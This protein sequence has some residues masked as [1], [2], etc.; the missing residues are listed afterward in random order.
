[1]YFQTYT[2]LFLSISLVIII[3]HIYKTST[4][5]IVT[6]Q[7]REM[8]LKGIEMS[9]S[10]TVSYLLVYIQLT[11][12]HL[13]IMCILEL[14]IA[15]MIIIILCG[16]WGWGIGVLFLFLYTACSPIINTGT[17]LFYNKRSIHTCS[18]CI[19]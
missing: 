3:K 11:E 14:N 4:W 13:F 19:K 8:W 7:P 18:T 2:R 1:M 16:G 12:F 9:H 6:I 5:W 17:N 15:V 10:I